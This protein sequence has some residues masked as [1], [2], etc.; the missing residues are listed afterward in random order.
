MIA[1]ERRTR[2][3]QRTKQRKNV[4]WCE[5]LYNSVR[6]CSFVYNKQHKKEKPESDHFYPSS[7][8]NAY[9]FHICMA[10][11]EGKKFLYVVMNAHSKKGAFD[12]ELLIEGDTSAQ[13]YCRNLFLPLNKL[14]KLLKETCYWEHQLLFFLQ[15]NWGLREAYVKNLNSARLIIEN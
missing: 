15:L 10:E 2:L 5:L 4:F 14:H 7:L 3:T 8:F 11:M 12:R 6:S 1:M 9:T 13:F